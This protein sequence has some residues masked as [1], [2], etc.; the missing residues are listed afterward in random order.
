MIEIENLSVSYGDV[1]AVNDV[2]LTIQKG[3]VT[4]I[5]GPNGCGKSTLI[6]A[7]SGLFK[8][9][10]DCI[11]VDGKCRK[12]YHRKE[13]AKKVSFLMQFSEVPE[14]MSVRDLVAFGRLPYHHMFE[15]LNDEDYRI[16]DWAMQKTRV[17]EFKDKFI[18]QL[19][20]GER[21]RVFVALAL[22][23]KTEV[24]IL[25]EPTNH[26]DIK[27]QHE[28]LELICKLNL[29]EELTI[30]CVLHDVNHALRYS[31]EIY[32]MKR[33]DIVIHGK[34]QT[35]ITKEIM[36]DVYDVHCRIEKIGEHLSV[37]VK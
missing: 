26:L 37:H 10:Q 33:G 22:A 36:H 12:D 11:K 23:Q 34:P 25:D 29:E 31:D 3:K 35:C 30:V 27:Y 14:G 15:R 2:S 32:V 17:Y 28:L 8:E 7:I 9:Y 19:S 18:H 1:L 20:G 6:K 13:F 16:V 21:Q 5:I 4:T 24:L